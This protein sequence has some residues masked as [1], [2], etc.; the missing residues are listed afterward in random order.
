MTLPG[1]TVL[2]LDLETD[3]RNHLWIV[4]SEPFDGRIALV[5]FT[6]HWPQS[7]LHWDCLI[8]DR[9][10]HPYLQHESCIYFLG[11]R[12]V[13]AEELDDRRRRGDLK[14]HDPC[15]P[16]LLRRIQ[17]RT[18]AHPLTPAPVIAAVRA[19]IDAAG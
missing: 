6:T 7:R 3:P 17:L 9:G 10:D 18:V 16:E 11:A 19:T 8:V 5:N 15:A 14:Q 1:E 4:A 13:D 2:E 12:L